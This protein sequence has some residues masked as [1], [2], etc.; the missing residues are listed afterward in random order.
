MANENSSTGLGLKEMVQPVKCL[1][2]KRKGLEVGMHPLNPS[3][4]EVE[5]DGSLKLADQET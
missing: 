4:G 5:R 3:T 2:S 1:L